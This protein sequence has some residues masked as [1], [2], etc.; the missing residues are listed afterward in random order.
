MSW[1]YVAYVA[2]DFLQQH[3]ISIRQ[4]KV[5]RQTNKQVANQ[6]NDQKSLIQ[7]LIKNNL[8]I[9]IHLNTLQNILPHAI[10]FDSHNTE[11]M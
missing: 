7:I 3:Y 9:S 1:S 6:A 10:A 4:Y 5:T 8:G 2:Y 11:Y